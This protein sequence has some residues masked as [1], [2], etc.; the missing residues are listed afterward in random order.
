MKKYFACFIFFAT[1]APVTTKTMDH[2]TFIREK[3]TLSKD[4]D[5]SFVSEDGRLRITSKPSN[6]SLVYKEKDGQLTTVH[7]FIT[8]IESKESE[9]TVHKFITETKSEKSVTEFTYFLSINKGKDFHKINTTA[10]KE[11]G[12]TEGFNGLEFAFKN[13]SDKTEGTFTGGKELPCTTIIKQNGKRIWGHFSD[14]YHTL[15]T[16]NLF[17]KMFALSYEEN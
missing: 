16:V 2:E 8:E 15:Q 1:L 4:K 6:L 3:Y 13:E 14:S 7:E 12:T 11:R 9:K 5:G 17:G 10:R